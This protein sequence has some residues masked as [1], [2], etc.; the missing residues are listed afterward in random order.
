MELQ[1]LLAKVELKEKNIDTALKLLQPINV[2]KV[3]SDKTV[4]ITLPFVRLVFEAGSSKGI[5]LL[6]IVLLT[7]ISLLLRIERANEGSI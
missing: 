6:F 2:N 1:I 4:L 5:Y 7:I 3:V